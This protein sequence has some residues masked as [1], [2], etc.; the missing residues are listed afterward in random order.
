LHCLQ[1]DKFLDSLDDIA[2][3]GIVLLDGM[4]IWGP[5]KASGL[6]ALKLW[7]ADW[8]QQYELNVAITASTATPTSNKVGAACRAC[9]E[10]R[11][12]MQ[13]LFCT[14]L[15][16]YGLAGGFVVRQRVLVEI[17]VAR[18]QQDEQQRG[19][20]LSFLH[21]RGRALV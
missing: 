15:P 2:V 17:A 9:N 11:C 4:H 13:L 21:M 1:G 12:R 8:L 20:T 3:D 6:T 5:S 7:V 19:L 18:E 14:I 10:L 16:C